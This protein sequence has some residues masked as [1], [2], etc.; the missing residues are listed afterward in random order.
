MVTLLYFVYFRFQT[1]ADYQ[2]LVPDAD[3]PLSQ[4]RGM[5]ILQETPPRLVFPTTFSRLEKPLEKYHFAP[6]IQPPKTTIVHTD[7]E[8][9]R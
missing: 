9:E 5:E 1:L 3:Y 8:E 4:V 6:D 2:Y 7:D